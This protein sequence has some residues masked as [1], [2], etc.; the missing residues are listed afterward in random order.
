M[1]NK[2][3][4]TKFKSTAVCCE[5]ILAFENT[6]CAQIWEDQTLGV[7]KS[8]RKPNV[9]HHKVFRYIMVWLTLNSVGV[10]ILTDEKM[11]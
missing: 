11:Q 6:D 9:I 4:H 8:R 5:A 2:K 10:N 1:I 7:A 3:V